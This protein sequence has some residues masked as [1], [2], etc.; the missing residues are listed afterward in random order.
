[1]TERFEDQVVIT[2]LGQSSLG[3]RLG[4]D[5][6]ELTAAACRAAVEDAGLSMRDID[7]LA[8]FPGAADLSRRSVTGPGLWE[9]QD[10]LGLELDW[11]SAGLEVASRRTVE[12]TWLISSMRDQG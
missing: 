10:M 5:D 4:R 11:Y 2:G 6:L 3:R 12:R 1:M 9:V 8:S 7:G